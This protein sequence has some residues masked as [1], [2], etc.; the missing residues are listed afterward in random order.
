MAYLS[1]VRDLNVT[2][3]ES[4]RDHGASGLDAEY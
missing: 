3:K 2:E 4:S 1:L